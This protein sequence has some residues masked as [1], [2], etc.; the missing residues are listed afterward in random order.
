M[1]VVFLFAW[2]KFP[3]NQ[4]QNYLAAFSCEKWNRL[5][6]TRIFVNLQTVAQCLCMFNAYIA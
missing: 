6:M 4:A 3:I 2:W 5:T 1:D